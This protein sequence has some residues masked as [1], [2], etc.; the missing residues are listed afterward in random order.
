MTVTADVGNIYEYTGSLANILAGGL[1]NT[2]LINTGSGPV[3]GQFVD[4]NGQLTQSDDGT[5]TVSIGGAPPEAIDYIGSGTISTVSAL[6]ITLDT[7]AVMVFQVN[8]TTYIYAPDGLPILSLVSVSFDIDPNAAFDLSAAANGVVEGLDTGESMGLG[9]TDLQGDQIT[10]AADSIFGFGG[11]DTISA[12]GGDD[13]VYGGDG[14][15]VISGDQGNDSLFGD[16]G[17]DTLSGGSGD[18]EISGGDGA[19]VLTG[20]DGADSFIVSGADTITDFDVVTGVGDGSS[21]NNDFVDL[22][23]VYNDV[24]LADWNAANPSQQYLTPLAWMRADL[25]DNG[26]LDQAGGLSIQ[27]G[28]VTVNPNAL[29]AENTGVVCFVTGTRIATMKGLVAVEDLQVGDLVLTYD[30]GY[31]EVRWIGN[32][33]VSYAELASNDLICPVRIEAGV[34]GNGL[35]ERR[36]H[37]TRQHRVLVKSPVSERMFGSRE[38]LVPAKDLRGIPGIETVRPPAGTEYWHIMFDDHEIVFSESAPSESLFFGPQASVMLPRQAHDELLMLFPNIA[39]AHA[40]MA[41]DEVRGAK[42]RQF[43][44]RVTRNER[45]V[46]EDG[47]KPRQSRAD[48]VRLVGNG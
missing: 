28:G 31:Q 19:D 48:D 37:L 8:G 39:N 33:K 43:V 23:A 18:D 32:R 24:T 41:R 14:E 11:N 36:L 30:H 45:M 34:L 6:G 16:A 46:F 47:G 20:G 25:A 12:A 35:P 3:D 17:N 29:T 21:G 13:V 44:D 4:N 10:V 15:D 1:L 27:S 9:Y 26:V 38:V 5:T 7:R 40:V 2:S 42:A 22:S